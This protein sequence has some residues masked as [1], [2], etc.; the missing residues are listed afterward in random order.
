M[1]HNERT[2]LHEKDRR[3]AEA[4]FLTI[5]R[6]PNQRIGRLTLMTLMTDPAVRL[7]M[8]PTAEGAISDLYEQMRDEEI[9]ALGPTPPAIERIR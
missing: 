9:N 4:I 3:F 1:P 2:S 5:P 7:A 6:L 8:G